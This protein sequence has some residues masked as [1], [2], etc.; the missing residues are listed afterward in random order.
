MLGFPST[1]TFNVASATN[2]PDVFV[3]FHNHPKPF[4]IKKRI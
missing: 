2:P 4:Q 1:T 3:F